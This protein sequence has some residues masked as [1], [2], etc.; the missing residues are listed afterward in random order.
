MIFLLIIFAVLLNFVAGVLLMISKSFVLLIQLMIAHFMLS[1]TDCIHGWCT[2]N[3]MKRNTG[4][5]RGT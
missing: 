3:V 5:K 4:K 1:D 2:A